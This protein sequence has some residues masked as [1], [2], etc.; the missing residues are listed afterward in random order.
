MRQ[1][2]PVYKSAQANSTFVASFIPVRKIAAASSTNR[3]LGEDGAPIATIH[4]VSPDPLLGSTKIDPQGRLVD[5]SNRIRQRRRFSWRQGLTI[6]GSAAAA[7]ASHQVMLMQASHQEK[8]AAFIPAGLVF[9]GSLANLGTIAHTQSSNNRAHMIAM[10]YFGRQSAHPNMAIPAS[11]AENSHYVL[12][13][14]PIPPRATAIVTL[15]DRLL[16]SQDVDALRK[17][18]SEDL[19]LQS[20]VH[21]G[22]G[23]D[24]KMRMFLKTRHW[25]AISS[26]LGKIW[27][28]GNGKDGHISSKDTAI[29]RVRGWGTYAVRPVMDTANDKPIAFTLAEIHP[30]AAFALNPPH[31]DI[32]NEMHVLNPQ[33]AAILVPRAEK[34]LGGKEPEFVEWGVW[35][36]GRL[37]SRLDDLKKIA[38]TS[39]RKSKVTHVQMYLDMK[40][41]KLWNDTYGH[42]AGDWALQQFVKAIYINMRPQDERDQI[43]RREGD[44]FSFTLAIEKSELPDGQS[45]LDFAHAWFER[46]NNNLLGKYDEFC[47]EIDQ[48]GWK[49]I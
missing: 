37:T 30:L 4:F 3:I 31:P 46:F 22:N 33:L 32:A 29:L 8:P 10:R 36:K 7:M 16:A 25:S 2:R 45:P 20:L 38:K 49:P 48:K 11:L 44:G 27:S 43:I 18:S 42:A 13:T 12:S 41:L 40:H 17:E 1:S 21:G 35:S 9:L 5:D 23:Y 26:H 6:V 14:T 34:L 15:V 47:Q 28:N 19:A 39:Q 24:E